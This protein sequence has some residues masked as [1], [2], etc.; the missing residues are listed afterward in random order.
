M[1]LQPL[2]DRLIVEALEEDG[3]TASGI[4]LP[5]SA[6]EKPQRGLVLA[7][8]PG[9]RDEDGKRVVMDVVAGDEIVFAKYGGTEIT[10][11]SDE[12]LILRESDV[13]AKVVESRKPVG[14][15]A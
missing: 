3:S 9:A 1:D 12:V 7:V 2:N 5:D 8:G 4:V 11:G 10:L 6:R 14:A 15:K 13:L